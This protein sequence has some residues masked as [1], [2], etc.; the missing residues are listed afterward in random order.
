MLSHAIDNPEELVRGYAAWELGRIGGEKARSVLE[1]R[2]K[3]ES[4]GYAISEIRAALESQFSM[5][6][7]IVAAACHSTL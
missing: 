1:R 7:M 3:K 6:H 4:S 2:L 5:L